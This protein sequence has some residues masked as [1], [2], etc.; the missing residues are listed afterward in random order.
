[1][2]K[3]YENRFPNLHAK[4]KNQHE[5]IGTI[6]EVLDL[7]CKHLF[8]L[9]ELEQAVTD[10]GWRGSY[11]DFFENCIRNSGNGFD[12]G[13]V[14]E[15]LLPYIHRTMNTDQWSENDYTVPTRCTHEVGFK[16][17]L[18]ARKL[19]PDLDDNEVLK[20]YAFVPIDMCRTAWAGKH[21][22]TNNS[23]LP[24]AQVIELDH[25][26]F[27]RDQLSQNQAMYIR[28]SKGDNKGL[29]QWILL[30]YKNKH[31][32][33]YSESPIAEDDKLKIFSLLSEEPTLE[34]GTSALSMSSGMRACA[35]YAQEV[36]K[37]AALS[38]SADYFSLLVEWSWWTASY[39]DFS[40]FNW[41]YFK[42]NVLRYYPNNAPLDR[43]RFVDFQT[44]LQPNED[45]K[46]NEHQQMRSYFLGLDKTLFNTDPKIL[47]LD[48]ETHTITLKVP[49]IDLKKYNEIDRVSR[50]YC[51]QLH[52]DGLG[53]Y[54]NHAKQKTLKGPKN[55]DNVATLFVLNTF[56][57][58][59][60]EKYLV[61]ELPIEYQLS[62]QEQSL[63]IYLMQRNPFV[64]R[65]E[66]RCNNQSLDVINENLQPI[67]ARNR[68]LSINGYLPPLIDEFWNVS[69]EYWV[70]YLK[71]SP[72]LLSD[73][74]DV[75][76]FKNCVMEMGLRGLQPLLNY[77][78]N[79]ED[80][81]KSY[82]NKLL[83]NTENPLVFYAGCPA[84]EVRA[85]TH[86]LIQ[87]LQQ[88]KYFPFKQFQFSFVPGANT[89]I[90]VL[91]EQLNELNYFEKISLTDCTTPERI[92][93]L[94]KFL[95]EVVSRASKNESWTCPIHIPELEKPSS[96]PQ[97]AKIYDLYNDLNNILVQRARK[98][99]DNDL[100]KI[101]LFKNASQVVVEE[102]EDDVEDIQVKKKKGVE[103]EALVRKFEKDS[104]KTFGKQPLSLVRAG[105]IA[106]QMQQQQQ[107]KQE[108]S[109]SLEN[110]MEKGTAYEDVLP[111]L[112]IDYRNIHEQLW[113]YYQDLNLDYPI[114]SRKAIL[115]DGPE[116]ILEKFFHTWVNANPTIS[117][118]H[119]IQKMTP[120]AAQMLLKYHRQLSGGL[121]V[122]NLPRGF[123]TQRL[124]SGELVLGYKPTLGYTT[125]HNPLTLQLTT[126]IPK[127]E[128][129]LGDYRQFNK[130]EFPSLEALKAQMQLLAEMQPELPKE[131]RAKRLETLW[132]KKELTN[133]WKVF[134][135][136]GENREWAINN[137][138]LFYSGFR[139]SIDPN[140]IARW[141]SEKPHK[142]ETERAIGL[143]LQ[144]IY[145]N[146]EQAGQKDR[147]FELLHRNRNVK[148]L[149]QIYSRFGN[150]GLERFS[151]LL[152]TMEDRLG[153]EFLEAFSEIYLFHCATYSSLLQEYALTTFD[154]ILAELSSDESGLE[155]K[156]FIVFLNMQMNAAGW[157]DITTLWKGFNYF[158]SHIKDMGLEK[159]FTPELLRSL[160]PKGQ[161]LFPCFQRILKSMENI[162]S[163]QLQTEFI[164]ALPDSDL[165]EGGVPYAVCHE[166]F[167]LVDK[168]LKLDRFHNGSPTYSPPMEKL[169]TDAWIQP[170][171]TNRALASKSHIKPDDY[172]RLS[173]E[174]L[175]PV[176]LVWAS[177]TEWLNAQTF[178][179]F[180]H[181]DKNQSVLK[182]VAEHLYRV[183][184]VTHQ[185]KRRFPLEIFGL[186]GNHA[187]KLRNILGKYPNKTT[188]FECLNILPGDVRE[189]NLARIFTLFDNISAQ[190]KHLDQGLLLTTVYGLSEV[191]LKAFFDATERVKRVTSNELTIL[192]NQLQSLDP[193][194]LPDEI[195]RRKAIWQAMLDGIQHMDD[196]PLETTEK[197]KELMHKLRDTY[198]LKFKSS[199][200][201]DYRVVKQD[202]LK[203]L[204]LDKFFEEHYRRISKF[205]TN[206]IAVSESQLENQPLKPIVEFF[207]RLQ[208]NKTYI[209]EVEPLLGTLEKVLEKHKR[210]VW[211][212]VYFD[213]LLRSLQPQDSTS[214]FPISILEA[215]LT[216]QN[217]P[218]IPGTIDE[219][220]SDFD[221]EGKWNSI[222]GLILSKAESFDR[223]Q[224][225]NLARLAIRT[226][227]APEFITALIMDLTHKD[228][229]ALRESILA[230]L[231]T[232]EKP[233]EQF[234]PIFRQCTDIIRIEHDPISKEDWKAT[235]QLW[236][237][238][239]TKYPVLED[240][241][242]LDKLDPAKK[243]L[244]LHITAWSS[245]FSNQY[246]TVPRADYLK[247]DNPKIVKLVAR[248]GKLSIEELNEL[249][250][251]YPAKPA[252]D[253]RNLLTF[254]KNNEDQPIKKAMEHFLTKEQSK[255]RQDYQCL[256]STREADL[257]RMLE[258][259]V[260]ARGKEVTPL[261]VKSGTQLTLMFQYLKQLEQGVTQLGGY[262]KT[263]GEMTEEELKEA[264][265][266]C[267][268]TSQDNPTNMQAETQVWAILFEVLG[269]TTG[270]YPHLAQQFALIANDLLLSDDPSSILQLKTGEGK[271]H[272]VALRAARHVGLGKKVD[273]CTAKWS[274]AER[275]L[276]DYKSFFD[277]LGISTANVQARSEHDTF[278]N[279]QVIYTTP[280]DLSL[281]LDEQA[282]Q[283]KPIPIEPRNRVGLG[284]EFDFLYYEGQKT[285]FNYARHTGITPKEMA[286]FYQGLNKFYDQLPEEIKNNARENRITQKDIINC[287]V[288]LAERAKEDGLLYLESISPMELLGWLQSTY[289]AA[290]LQFGVQYTVRL[291]QVKIG[292]EEFPLR[293]IYPLTKDMQAAVGSSFSHGVHQLLAARLNE[294]AALKDEPQ[295][296]HVH[297]ESHII[298]S[299]VFS[300][301]L[302]TLWG[303]WEGFTGTVSSSQ[304]HELNEEHKTAVLR[305]PTNQRDLRKW[306]APQFFDHRNIEKAQE[307][308]LK[309]IAS[310]IKQRIR[311]KK[312]IL[313][314]C[315][316]DAEVLKMTAAI[317]EYFTEEEYNQYFLSYTNES[318]ESPAEILRRKKQMEG[319]YLEQK[320][321]GVVLIAAGFGR[322]DNVGV[323]TVILGSVQDENDLEQKGGRTARNGEEGEVLQYYI[324]K[325]IDEELMGW[326]KFLADSKLL[327]GVIEELVR[328][329]HPLKAAFKEDEAPDFSAYKPTDK[330]NLLLRL[331]EYSAD[332]DNYLSRF[333]HEAKAKRS[334][335]GINKIGK[336]DPQK[337]DQL[338]KEFANYLTDLEK[339]WL[340]IQT[341][342]KR[343]PEE[344]ILE[345]K[346]FMAEGCERNGRLYSM[347][348]DLDG[349]KMEIDVPNQPK[350]ILDTPEESRKNQL[351]IAVQGLVLRI[352]NL[353]EDFKSWNQLITDISKMTELQMGALLHVYEN[354]K[355]IQFSELQKQ[356][357][358][359]IKDRD[360]TEQIKELHNQRKV[361]K[362]S[363]L[364]FELEPKQ[365]E[366]M[367]KALL[368]MHP[369]ASNLALEYILS[370]KYSG[371]KYV[372]QILPMLQYSA[373]NPDLSLSFWNNPIIRDSLAT[374]PA[375]C[376][377]EK[378]YLDA[379]HLIAI[380]NFL[381]RFI[382]V[383]E[384]EQTYSDL[385]NQFVIGMSNQPEHRKRLLAQY[386]AIL[387]RTGL[388]SADLLKRFAE[389][390][391]N[392]KSPEHFNVLK[393]FVEKM[394][395]EYEAPRVSIKELDAIWN[396]MT[397]VGPRIVEFLPL[398][399]QIL[400]TEGKEFVA[401]FNSI[402]K[403]QPEL[404][405]NSQ[406]F[407]KEFFSPSL[408]TKKQ[409][410]IEEYNTVLE[411][412]KALFSNEK[413]KFDR[414]MQ[415]F[416]SGRDF[417]SATEFNGIKI[418]LDKINFES[419]K[420]N[421][422]RYSTKDIHYLLS[423][424]HNFPEHE[425]DWLFI[426]PAFVKYLDSDSYQDL[427]SEQGISLIGIKNLLEAQIVEKD[428]ACYDVLASLSFVEMQQLLYFSKT[429]PQHAQNLLAI[430][431]LITYMTQLGDRE[432]EEKTFQ[433]I[434]A[435]LEN[436]KDTNTPLRAVRVAFNKD[437]M[438]S[439]DRL[440]MLLKLSDNN[441]DHE[442]DILLS[443]LAALDPLSNEQEKMIKLFFDNR[444]NLE[445]WIK[446]SFMTYSR[447][448]RVALM[449]MLKNESFVSRTSPYGYSRNENN[450]LYQ[451]GLDVY[452]A[453]IYQVLQTPQ[454]KNQSRELSPEQQKEVLKVMGELETIGSNPPKFKPK[455]EGEARKDLDKAIQAQINAYDNLWFKDT[456]R[457]RDMKVQI[458]E[459]KTLV[460]NK[461]KSY[462]E[463][464]DKVREI[465]RDLM[466]YDSEKAS[467]QL[468]PMFH[469]RGQSRLYRTFND[470]ED[471]ILK[472]WTDSAHKDVSKSKDYSTVYMR[473]R[474]QYVD[475]FKKALDTWNTNNNDRYR[476]FKDSSVSKMYK[477]MQ[478]LGTNQGVVEYLREN[479]AQVKKLPG[480]LKAIAK[481][482]LAHSVDDN[483][484]HID[485][486]ANN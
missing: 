306:P 446:N 290:T 294:K 339:K 242:A 475:A 234:G 303:H 10:D 276:L 293:E 210:G 225:A 401:R 85:Y 444:R 246:P 21:H 183:F 281:F 165:T 180:L 55:Y 212:C 388:P 355:T 342:F 226:V 390:G 259:T 284:D 20:N 195:D 230:R 410:K 90:I 22:S 76:E 425:N 235:S 331:R 338:I 135:A 310:D 346:G 389:I 23:H 1:M 132:H 193:D 142:L 457:F 360:V 299:Q 433:S 44:S 371:K 78:S 228:Y 350:F 25:I 264:F 357:S 58:C 317:K 107:I 288:F 273:V 431:P 189:E 484:L 84:E 45:G 110:E 127:I 14:S 124:G 291:E 418:L 203:D 155:K 336:A 222:F 105:G 80:E 96:N 62:P 104:D 120:Y 358:T 13:E 119:T 63:I 199:I 238:I 94:G 347:F 220:Q 196:H 148:G 137:W 81:L 292:E 368:V 66:N 257:A 24:A 327:A 91:L 42:E 485:V 169:F 334:S 30:Y 409:V 458:D 170:L 114:D 392:F 172:K 201:G 439:L 393:R 245:F 166:G 129:I 11:V 109:R 311:E 112:L 476:L 315:A 185:A 471:L 254:I 7:K 184:Y 351:Q 260:V 396:N 367:H 248:L 17:K 474:D 283:G 213:R 40:E 48:P 5:N 164:K 144:N 324:T 54:E 178:L 65:F 38:T 437:P 452:K 188:F 26:E 412:L 322:G 82:F 441:K 274:L 174:N 403:L 335:E 287:Y 326:N 224:Q 251:N 277:F 486:A 296:Y 130:E 202:D 217:S 398:I 250:Q 265:R 177:H 99:N 77:L 146:V 320:E 182:D 330:F 59:A 463:L 229:E 60:K 304:S 414:A 472:S 417:E 316:T 455:P 117:A 448:E 405:V 113:K 429:Y 451:A 216:E 481:E 32:F 35:Q 340:E 139:S 318:Y 408:K 102:L 46:E 239:L 449:D 16:E 8:Y 214:S 309:K 12:P 153:K 416:G 424:V 479:P 384:N 37:G 223:V 205:F 366:I 477:Y 52:W 295:N 197:R 361:E 374:L 89:D 298:S 73:K 428:K 269:R 267:S 375:S 87:H 307:V 430:K 163:L 79:K 43:F 219:V 190:Y 88:E 442:V 125:D 255:F 413:Y 247:G 39:P 158:Y 381:D 173:L 231:L 198:G 133:T 445:A 123:Y 209:N 268:K 154:A 186:L 68:W 244:V 56:R 399:E 103:S 289:E 159:E 362:L 376:F 483:A 28:S 423:L 364:K 313:W 187:E 29:S 466:A 343:K 121:N 421:L 323:E 382:D 61:V 176:A 136:K 171:H 150:Y 435:L 6:L 19:L 380:K 348:H 308:R 271:S 227:E 2:R 211:T 236:I 404:I 92:D 402:F 118:K 337:K 365:E 344:C 67:F 74:K 352:A 51:R 272:F 147:I 194:T 419:L 122:S 464:M 106:L 321:R 314:C 280:G 353:S 363:D 266:E 249:A 97:L 279:A 240:K 278:V 95:E 232:S 27:I 482:V 453:H 302:K 478:L 34:G 263:I 333:Y 181:A 301:R 286:W 329:D 149:G 237:E 300:Q 218:F 64:C 373:A 450:A 462:E 167:V 387:E 206:H 465:K 312:S 438:Q 126:A 328:V 49:V 319:D 253:T 391:K 111:P 456:Q 86:A 31:P 432:K 156:L 18:K 200:S 70:A 258:L 101:E 36:V 345:L 98:K 143:L 394:K 395:K 469:F 427:S 383:K 297:P 233:V 422:K 157:E 275:D 175:S 221:K 261:D 332:K 282:S 161:N 460:G 461:G 108:R 140:I 241:F 47:S 208:L 454:F 4:Y 152:L 72:D 75:I 415:L 93:A 141:F 53:V 207:K 50:G 377:K 215:I 252:P 138:E 145:L 325:E 162:P 100:L 349:F 151:N 385:F 168:S 285:Q 341:R 356:V 262:E 447:E 420:D 160:E 354:T 270:K 69:A 372:V 378:V 191:E 386:E 467:K 406:D 359:L 204:G 434:F 305:V 459:L 71:T 57:S 443:S 370:P 379:D 436:I 400:S 41:Q 470:I 256:S 407:L 128:P 440:P 116:E 15:T 3:F 115:G 473:S 83:R 411:G 243:A 134:L 9:E 179:D 192:S 468:F 397:N 480:A 131:E 426:A 33:V 369:L